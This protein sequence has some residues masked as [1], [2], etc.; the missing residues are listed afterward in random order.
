[1]N[2][3][4]IETA[5]QKEILA[6]L[7]QAYEAEFSKITGKIPEANGIFKPDT[8]I[9][10]HHEGYLLFDNNHRPI[11]FCIKGTVGA[12]HDISEFYIVPAVRRQGWGQ[13]FAFAIFKNYSGPWQVRQIIGA[14]RAQQ[15][16]RTA[17]QSFT[18]GRF[19]EVLSSDP[20]WGQV[21]LQTFETKKTG[22]S[23]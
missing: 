13:K 18:S 4:R 9:D 1:M 10:E 16:W 5:E 22:G 7:T 15:F 3:V 17:I 11:G 21:I 6:H 12:I 19:E 20:D 8:Q 14:D 2:I 23:D